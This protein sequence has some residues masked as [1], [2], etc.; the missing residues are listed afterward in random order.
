MKIHSHI[1]HLGKQGAT[2]LS[3]NIYHL[4][5]LSSYHFILLFG[6]NSSY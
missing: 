1:I 4:H 5:Q 6:M 3:T 2:W